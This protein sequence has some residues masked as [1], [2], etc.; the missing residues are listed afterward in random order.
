M[1]YYLNIFLFGLMIG[2][3]LN[4]F[5]YEV[6]LIVRSLCPGFKFHKKA[7]MSLCCCSNSVGV[8]WQQIFAKILLLPTNNLISVYSI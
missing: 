7:E 1:K 4:G 3:N 5:L 6:S 2:S 8:Y